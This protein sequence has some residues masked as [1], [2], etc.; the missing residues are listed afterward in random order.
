MNWYYVRGGSRNGP[1]DDDA[2]KRLIAVGE[3]KP[4]DLVWNDTMGSKWVEAFTVPGLFTRPDDAS[5][6]A[7]FP[8]SF[9]GA[10]STAPGQTPNRELTARARLAVGAMGHRRGGDGDLHGDIHRM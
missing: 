9:P 10:A 7:A 1:I 5:A 6:A 3:L 8:L 2:L 4:N